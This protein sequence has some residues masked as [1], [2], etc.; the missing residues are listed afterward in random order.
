MPEKLPIY[1]YRIEKVSAKN[2][3]DLNKELSKVGVH[4]RDVIN[5]AVVPIP[6]GSY[7]AFFVVKRMC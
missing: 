6:A 1:E 3:D 4:P 2:M 7:I 5:V